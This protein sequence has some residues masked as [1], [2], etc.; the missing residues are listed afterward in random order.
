MQIILYVLGVS[1]AN[2]GLA[3]LL[4]VILLLPLGWVS[5]KFLRSPSKKSGNEI[6]ET[7]LALVFVFYLGAFIWLDMVWELSLGIVI[8]AYLLATTEQKGTPVFLWALFG[9]YALLDIW[10]LVS[11]IALGDNIL[12]EGAY[13]LTDPLIYV[14]WIMMIL[15]AFHTILL[16][17]L[18]KFVLRPA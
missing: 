5:L 18:N 2:M 7:A 10:R 6:P 9:P 17:S 12:Y 13:V 11:Y 1:A 15:L 8:F 4:K 14:P 16:L 3:T